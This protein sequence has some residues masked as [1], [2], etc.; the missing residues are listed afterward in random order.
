MH[1]QLIQRIHN[2]EIADA[3]QD[4]QLLKIA[5]RSKESH[6]AEARQPRKAV[7]DHC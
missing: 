6:R 5:E 2:Q 7:P 4:P 1:T 3:I